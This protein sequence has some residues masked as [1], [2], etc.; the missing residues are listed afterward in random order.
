MEKEI[1]FLMTQ[2]VKSQCTLKWPYMIQRAGDEAGRWPLGRR[3][4]FPQWGQ[5]HPG[6]L[7]RS[8]AAPLL[9]KASKWADV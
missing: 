8:G 4:P 3:C 5:E 9:P 7:S 6:P 2:Q 1:C